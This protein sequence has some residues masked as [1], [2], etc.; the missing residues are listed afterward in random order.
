MNHAT[1]TTFLADP[2]YPGARK[3]LSRQSE[4]IQLTHLLADILVCGREAEHD[5]LLQVTRLAN[6]LN[7]KG[8]SDDEVRREFAEA[9]QAG[10]FYS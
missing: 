3:V 9:L 10:K 6:A 4:F 2:N 7:E 8:F 1:S 5:E